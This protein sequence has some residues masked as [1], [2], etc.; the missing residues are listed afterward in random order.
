MRLAV[1]ALFGMAATVSAKYLS[2]GIEEAPEV[3]NSIET[4]M[5]T[6]LISTTEEEQNPPVV[7]QSGERIA[8]IMTRMK[9]KHWVAL[10]NVLEKVTVDTTPEEFDALVKENF[11]T[12]APKFYERYV[13]NKDK[14]HEKLKKK[15]ECIKDGTCKAGVKKRARDEFRKWK[16]TKEERKKAREED[17]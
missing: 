14:V 10:K 4:G 15:Q 2:T 6:D 8:K 9:K 7:G 1:L 16:M 3:T 13:K 12:I 17:S 5:I 11:E